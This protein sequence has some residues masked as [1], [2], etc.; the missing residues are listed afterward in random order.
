MIKSK[1]FITGASGCVGHYVLDLFANNPNYDCYLLARTPEKIKIKASNFFPVKG[2]LEFIEEHET[3]ISEMNYL[4]HIATDW[5]NSDYAFLLNVTK[6]HKMFSYLNPDICKKVVYFSTASI[7]G[8]NNSPIKEAGTLGTGYVS[9]KYKAYTSLETLKISDRIVTLFP[10]LVFGGD[11]THPYSHVS[12]GIVPNKNY[13]K[14]LRFIYMDARFHFLHSKDIAKVTKYVME[15][16]VEKSS[17]VLGNK[18]LKGKDVIEILCNVFG[19]SIPFRI[20]INSKFLMFLAKILRIE[21]GSWDKHCIENPYFEYDTV[22]PDHFGM[23]TDYPSLK[24]MVVE[25]KNQG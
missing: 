3:L 2:N 6:S 5:S 1:V 10:T 14:L 21:V 4:I 17:Y 20:K 16:P 19:V 11:K 13:L 12:S 18:V 25:L 23:K 15:H 7:L 22:A 9:S 8:K 24:D